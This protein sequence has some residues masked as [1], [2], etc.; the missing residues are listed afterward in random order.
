M[1]HGKMYP[2]TLHINQ[3]HSAGFQDNGQGYFSFLS[4]LKSQGACSDI[5]F[6]CMDMFLHKTQYFEFSQGKLK[7]VLVKKSSLPDELLQEVSKQLG[8]D[9]SFDEKQLFSAWR[10]QSSNQLDDVDDDVQD[11]EEDTEGID[12]IFMSAQGHFRVSYIMNA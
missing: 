9:L 10:S 1:H 4:A 8:F 7:G 5:E 11:W 6:W 12:H 2:C 3:L